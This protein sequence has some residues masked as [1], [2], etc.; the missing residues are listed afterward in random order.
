MTR[1]FLVMVTG[2]THLYPA[3]TT[4]TLN[5]QQLLVGGPAGVHFLVTLQHH[6][7]TVTDR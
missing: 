6:R 1:Q 3:V 2:E 7:V 5:G 4:L